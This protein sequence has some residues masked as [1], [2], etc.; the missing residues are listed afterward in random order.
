MNSVHFYPGVK[1]TPNH[2]PHT[3]RMNSWERGNS[4]Y[5]QLIPPFS[6]IPLFELFTSEK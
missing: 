5:D 1:E 3:F 4:L 6:K 2:Q